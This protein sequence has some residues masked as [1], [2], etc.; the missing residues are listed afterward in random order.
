[1]IEI[2]E[3]PALTPNFFEAADNLEYLRIFVIMPSQYNL[4]VTHVRWLENFKKKF[5]KSHEFQTG[6]REFD[7]RYHLRPE[8]EQDKQLLKDSKFHESVITLEP[9]SVIEI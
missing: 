6:N 5:F 3:F 7:K 8:S 1:M 9:F 2:S 4:T